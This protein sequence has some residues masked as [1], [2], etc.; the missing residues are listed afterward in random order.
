M[1]HQNFEKYEVILPVVNEDYSTSSNCDEG[2]GG[3]EL[4]AMPAR[5]PSQHKRAIDATSMQ[6]V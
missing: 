1:D 4:K 5:H 6:S 3:F 2:G